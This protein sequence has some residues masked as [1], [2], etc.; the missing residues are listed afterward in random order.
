[1]VTERAPSLRH[2]Q[3]GLW[4]TVVAATFVLCPAMLHGQQPDAVAEYINAQL[5]WRL[6]PGLSLVVLKGG[7]VI[8]AE[9]YGL[10]NRERADSVRRS[11][12]FHLGSVGKQF[13]AAA[14]LVLAQDGRVRI[15]D[16]V[17][18]YLRSTPP[19]WRGITIRHLLT[20][21]SGLGNYDDAVDLTRE[22]T[23]DELV[24][25]IASQPLE[26]RPGEKYRYSNSGYLLLGLIVEAASG[27]RPVISWRVACS[28][29]SACSRRVLPDGTSGRSR[30]RRMAIVAS[31]TAR[32]SRHR[33][34]RV[35]SIA[36]AMAASI[37]RVP[38][39]RSGIAHSTKIHCSRV[40]AAP[41]CGLLS[42]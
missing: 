35:P 25:F 37:R 28:R 27:E 12:L 2:A 30:P 26:F 8:R 9:G 16:A 19:A 7:R 33:R 14:I 13:T 5:Q 3:H 4:T 18:S 17:S 29:R 23:S 20:H 11:T 34:C 32:S 38:I 41:P 10:A 1:M 39:W 31:T 24:A 22:Y 40:P 21:T 15:D 36:P 42:G 6:I